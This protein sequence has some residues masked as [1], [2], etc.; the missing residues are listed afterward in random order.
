MPIPETLAEA[1]I[2]WANASV[3]ISYSIKFEALPGQTCVGIAIVADIG[4]SRAEALSVSYWSTLSHP[5][6]HLTAPSRL[7]KWYAEKDNSDMARNSEFCPASFQLPGGVNRFCWLK[8]ISLD[9]FFVSCVACL[10]W[11]VPQTLCFCV[12][13]EN[14]REI[15]GCMQIIWNRTET[16]LRQVE[17]KLRPDTNAFLINAAS[18]AR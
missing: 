6:A 13:P 10:P 7:G 15:V 16:F 11:S 4:N 17:F 9:F 18:V 1:N 3:D 12:C 14:L 2:D 5:L 8:R